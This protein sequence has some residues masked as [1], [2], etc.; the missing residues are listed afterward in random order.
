MGFTGIVMRAGR[1]FNQRRGISKCDEE[2]SP[3]PKAL[4]LPA[5]HFEISAHGGSW[6]PWLELSEVE[7]FAV[8]VVIG[9]SVLAKYLG[10]YQ[11]I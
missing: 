4:R 3:I 2:S 6:T 8:Q 1:L 5:L 9:R 11:W 7:S 10:S